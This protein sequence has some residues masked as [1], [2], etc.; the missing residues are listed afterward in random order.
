MKPLE[1]SNKKSTPYDRS[2]T[3]FTEPIKKE[4]KPKQAIQ[5][6]Y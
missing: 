5:N 4:V 1:S 2:P 3:K 6:I